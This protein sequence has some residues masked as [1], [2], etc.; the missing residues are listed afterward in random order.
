MSGT[1]ESVMRYRRV[2]TNGMPELKDALERK[3]ITLYRADQILRLPTYREQR[4]ALKA[5]TARTL[6]H[7]EGQAIAARALRR[8]LSQ[9][10][11]V[12]LYQA[13]SLICEAVGPTPS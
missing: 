12:D 3:L 6:E 1:S 8:Y 5:W 7:R 10:S 13:C 11:A 9:S 4:I 2:Y